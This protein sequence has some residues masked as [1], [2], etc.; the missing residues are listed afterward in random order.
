MDFVRSVDLPAPMQARMP[1]IC[2]QLPP[3]VMS[4]TIRVSSL[5]SEMRSSGEQVLVNL[6]NVARKALCAKLEY[7]K[8]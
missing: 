8:S 5:G 1:S 7:A 6:T 3:K 2:I 4:L